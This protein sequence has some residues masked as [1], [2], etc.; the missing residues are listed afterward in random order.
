MKKGILILM[1]M[2]TAV[3]LLAQ[4]DP[5]AYFIGAETQSYVTENVN[6]EPLLIQISAKLSDPIIQVQPSP[7]FLKM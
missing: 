5:V 2:F 6:V 4:P 1:L 7:L 3:M